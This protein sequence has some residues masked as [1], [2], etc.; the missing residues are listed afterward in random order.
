MTAGPG[1]P[2]A[3]RARDR[4]RVLVALRS[5]DRA[6]A[7]A[8][9][10]ARAQEPA[11]GVVHHLP[12]RVRLRLAG[13]TAGDAAR[14]AAYLREQ[15]GVSDAVARLESASVLVRFDAALTSADAVVALARRSGR[16]LWPEVTAPPEGGLAPAEVSV[17][18]TMVLAA[19]LA[20][21][22]PAPL[23]AAAVAATALPSA[24]RALRAVAERRLSV[25]VLDVAAIVSSIATGR[26]ANASLM[27]WLLGVGDLVLDRT[28]DRARAAISRLMQ[29]DVSDAWRL[30]GGGTRRVPPH[31]LAVGDRIVVYPGARVAA[32]G[33]IVEGEASVDEKALTGE[34]LPRTRSVGDRVLAATVVVDGQIVV[35][36]DRVGTSTTAARIVSILQGAGSKPMTLQRSVEAVADRLVA[37][38][39]A[40]AIAAGA[41]TGQV[42]RTTSVLTTDFG[43]GVRV[44]VPLAAL[45]AMM[46]AAREGVLVKG[47]QYLERLARAD[48]VVFDKT[49]TLT[50][51][52]PE[53]LDVTPLGTWPIEAAIAFA[54]AAEAHHRHPVAVSIRRH[55]ERLGAV[56]PARVR[57]ERYSIGKGVRAVVDGCVVIVGRRQLLREHGI[58]TAATAPVRARHRVLGASSL[59]V[60]VDGRLQAAIGYAD[61]PRAESAAVVRALRAGGRREVILMSGDMRRTADA[62]GA[63]LGLDRVMA[64]LLPEDKAA[65]IRALQRAGRIV[66]MVGDGINDAPALALADVGISLHGG[67]D[68]ALET[69]D[70]VL[71]DGGLAALPRAFAI[72]ERAMRS[73]RLGLLSVLGPN[74]VA[75]VLG[76]LGLLPPALATAINNGSTIVGALAGAA[77]LLLA[78]GSRAA[79]LSAASARRARTGAPRRR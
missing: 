48:T 69:A 12:G 29:L 27:T 41:L 5:R 6:A 34:S 73:V 43:T 55:A 57:Q 74:A 40:L 49:G 66:A 36:V 52:E 11:V 68:V 14:L 54:A 25:D 1:E 59:F 22:L 60:A 15:P 53:V 28:A 32:D 35:Q 26:Y 61:R 2:R 3:A 56:V 16:A 19:T 58:D 62:I 79:P 30:E 51:G 64:E 9:R 10:A 4:D 23:L 24:R 20:E 63:S 31:R 45:S 70:V 75:I 33:I 18:N 65:S 17:L 7:T 39:F 72:A 38:T 8:R 42:D 47:A 21:A 37:P 50:R 46:L 76:A 78:P 13:A 71:L 67:A 44:T 77:P